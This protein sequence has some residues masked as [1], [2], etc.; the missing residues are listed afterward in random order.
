MSQFNTMTPIWPRIVV[1][2]L[3]FASHQACADNLITNGN[4][5]PASSVTLTNNAASIGAGSTAVPGWTTALG[6]GTGAGNYVAGTGSGDTWIPNPPTTSVYGTTIFAVQ[7]DSTNS[8]SNPTV[9]GNNSIT[10]NQTISIVSGRQYSLTFYINSESKTSVNGADGTVQVAGTSSGGATLNVTNATSSGVTGSSAT[11]GSGGLVTLKTGV[12]TG[13]QAQPWAKIVVLFTA[14]SNGDVQ[15]TFTDTGTSDS[16]DM[17]L[18]GVSLSTVTPEF[19]HWSIA[20]LFVIGCVSYE[21]TS[22]SRRW[23]SSPRAT[24]PGLTVD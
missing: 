4:F 23:R 6:T 5:V 22:R 10:S 8:G 17:S 18:A 24:P 12:G 16:N 15:L 3:I 11:T 21:L 1:G 14:T 20:A 13:V 9:N 2:A 7:L 19:S